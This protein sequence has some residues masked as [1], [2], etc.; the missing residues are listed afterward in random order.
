[1]Q[2][3]HSVVL[4]TIKVLDTL[5]QPKPQ[6]IYSIKKTASPGKK[7]S[8]FYKKIVLSEAPSEHL[9]FYI[10]RTN[11]G[12]SAFIF[13][14]PISNRIYKYVYKSNIITDLKTKLNCRKKFKK[15]KT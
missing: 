11:I 12:N 7:L 10:S 8:D 9:Q 2:N 14:G 3:C 13:A 5:R 4:D 15:R 6:F 1:M